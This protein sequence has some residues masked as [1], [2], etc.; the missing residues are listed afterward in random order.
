MKLLTAARDLQFLRLDAETE[1]MTYLVLKL[2]NLVTFELHNP[3]AV[4]ADKM[5]VVRVIGVI[6]IVKFIVFAEIHFLNQTALR[7]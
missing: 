1:P 7:Q 6:W 2:L 4:L 3:L 5:I